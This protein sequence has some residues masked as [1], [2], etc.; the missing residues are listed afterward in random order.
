MQDGYN[1]NFK[2]MIKDEI[3]Q[4]FTMQVKIPIVFALEIENGLKVSLDN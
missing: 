2:N 3:V 1:I 4:L